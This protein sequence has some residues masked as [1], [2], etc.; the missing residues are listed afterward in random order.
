[1]FNDLPKSS[2]NEAAAPPFDNHSNSDLVVQE[3]RSPIPTPSFYLYSTSPPTR[4]A[5]PT[6]DHHDNDEPT[7]QESRRHNNMRTPDLITVSEPRSFGVSHIDLFRE[8]ENSWESFRWLRTSD[9]TSLRAELS[10]CED[11]TNQ[12]LQQ[13]PDSR[14]QVL[15]LARTK[16]LFM[17]IYS[18]DITTTCAVLQYWLSI[19]YDINEPDLSG[20][21]IFLHTCN[22]IHENMAMPPYRY[23]AVFLSLLIESG[24]NVHA[25]DLQTGRGALHL[26]I[27]SMASLFFPRLGCGNIEQILV[28]LLDAGCDPYARDHTGKAPVEYAKPNSRLFSGPSKAVWERA[29]DRTSATR[30]ARAKQGAKTR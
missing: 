24:A 9:F 19:G 26:V 10:H 6:T 8:V 29:M 16:G 3:S 23:W 5:S 11:T 1:M 4:I 13:S 17:P 21:T 27:I 12:C 30:R 25:K 28:L 2:H 15:D 22:S 18:K 20:C 14:R 7:I